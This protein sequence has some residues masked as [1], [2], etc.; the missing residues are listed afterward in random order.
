MLKIESLTKK[1]LLRNLLISV[2]SI[3]FF[4]FCLYPTCIIMRIFHHLEII[5]LKNLMYVLKNE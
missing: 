2:I 1:P 4:T 3:F 5:K